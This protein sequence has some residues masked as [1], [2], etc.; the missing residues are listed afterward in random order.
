MRK[1]SAK[2][3]PKCLK[4]D[5]KRQPCP[6]SEQYL[7]LFSEIQMISCQERLVTV[8]ETWLY[9]YNP[10]TNNNRVATKWLT[11][12]PK[13]IPSAKFAG[14]FSPRFFCDQDGIL[15]LIIFQRAKL[16]TRSINHLWWCNWRTFWSKDAAKNSPRVSCSCTK[17]TRL[18]QHL[19]RRRNWPTWA[20][21]HCLDNPPCFPGLALSDYHLFPWQKR[22]MKGRQ[23]SSDAKVIAATETW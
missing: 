5:Q 22:H 15:L 9:H 20:G 8:G 17:M 12:P 7:D 10:E 3:V 14:N 11:P 18:T 4:A 1:L 21:F 16:S 6:S 13:K 2:W 19:Q 23:F